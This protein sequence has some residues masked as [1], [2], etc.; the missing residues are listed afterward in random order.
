MAAAAVSSADAA[1]VARVPALLQAL[2]HLDG[3]ADKNT[4]PTLR[5]LLDVFFAG[6]IS[7]PTYPAAVAALLDGD[8]VSLLLARCDEAS[9]GGW[10]LVVLLQATF[11]S[12]PA[13]DRV[14]LAGFH[15]LGF[16]EHD[17]A[18]A[19]SIL[20]ILRNVAISETVTTSIY[21]EAGLATLRQL[22]SC[23][24]RF[25]SIEAFQLLGNVL[26]DASNAEM[27]AVSEFVTVVWLDKHLRQFVSLA[28]DLA[29]AHGVVYVC[30]CFLSEPGFEEAMRP[31]YHYFAIALSCLST[32]P[33]SEDLV[34]M[35]ECS[36]LCLINSAT[37]GLATYSAQAAVTL[38]HSQPGALASMAFLA[39]KRSPGLWVKMCS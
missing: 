34:D 3:S 5:E 25:S 2:R 26:C 27:Q 6:K 38:V 8:L 11:V 7:V 16:A 15:L 32:L 20:K 24:D 19:P 35:T 31:L 14:G 1:L 29:V 4:E 36:A 23:C 33:L 28:P 37:P 10:P 22:C 9:P 39:V 21:L 12:A 30:G 17:A 18:L 13:R